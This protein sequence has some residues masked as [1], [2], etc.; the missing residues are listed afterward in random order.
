MY[1]AR[2][3]IFGERGSRP[4]HLAELV[5]DF[6]PY[7]NIWK[8]CADVTR[9]VPEWIEGPFASLDPEKV[10]GMV[11]VW[12]RSTKKNLKAVDGPPREV[13]EA[14]LAKIQSFQELLPLVVALRNP[15]LKDRHWAKLSEDLGFAVNGKGPQLY[16][17]KGAQAGSRDAH[18]D[19]G[20]GEREREQGVLAGAHPR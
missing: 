16:P 6:E 14:L 15:G 1:A 13:G 4:K 18:R 19:R 3:E 20:E 5:K 17:A 12:D 10:S 9:T 2:Q 7:A 11:E 8:T